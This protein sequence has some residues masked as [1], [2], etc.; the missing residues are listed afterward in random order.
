MEVSIHLIW[1]SQGVRRLSIFVFSLEPAVYLLW[2]KAF[3]A[4]YKYALGQAALL[5]QLKQIHA[6]S[7][8]LILFLSVHIYI[9]KE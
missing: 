7:Y 2:D 5:V 9:R 1:R 6:H 8:D 3:E 4:I